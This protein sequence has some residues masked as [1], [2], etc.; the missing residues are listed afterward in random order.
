MAKWPRNL[1]ECLDDSGKLEV[2][3]FEVD[4]HSLAGLWDDV[5]MPVASKPEMG[6]EWVP[7]YVVVYRKLL[8]WSSSTTTLLVR[9][10]KA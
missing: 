8:N 5:A 6:L 10:E 2:E 1:L 9:R 4:F 3:V 7:A